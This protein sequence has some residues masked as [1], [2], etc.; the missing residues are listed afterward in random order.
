MVAAK[1]IKG[2]LKPRSTGSSAARV[3]WGD[4]EL[5]GKLGVLKEIPKNKISPDPLQPRKVIDPEALAELTQSLEEHGM[6]QPILVVESETGIGQY[7][8]LAGERRWRAAMASDKIQ[9]IPVIVRSDLTNELRILLAQIAENIHRQNMNPLETATA[10][11]RI[12]EAVN[13]NQDEAAKLL[14]I[15][16]SRLCQVLAVDDAPAKV[17]ALVETGIT[18]DV[19]VVAGLSILTDLNA[20]K[21]EELMDKAKKGEIKGVGLRTAVKDTVREEK[22]NLKQKRVAT[23]PTAQATT[24]LATSTEATTPLPVSETVE[25]V[26]NVNEVLNLKLEKRLV[27]ELVSFLRN[28][29]VSESNGVIG[30][31]LLAITPLNQHK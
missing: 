11:K 23:S 3:S 17:K 7:K 18:S 10:Y 21:A 29:E 15:S 26:T 14:G 5:L 30:R 4:E 6:L 24:D 8:I 13:H 28:I 25:V 22:A 20:S 19:N 2:G 31:F 12:Y 16:K 9:I 1:D 27:D